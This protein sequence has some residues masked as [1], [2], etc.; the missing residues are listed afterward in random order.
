MYNKI[1]ILI[2]KGAIVTIGKNFI[3]SSGDY[4]NPLS[5][6]MGGGIYAGRNAVIRIGNNVGVSSSCIWCINHISIGDNAK[7]GADVIIIDNDAH[8]LD[9][10]NRRNSELDIANSSPIHI[11]EDVLIGTRCI[12]LKGVSIGA[13][14][15]IGAGSVVTKDIPSDCIAAGN[16]CRVIKYL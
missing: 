10:I 13:R 5:R 4:Q 14:S 11:E 9:Y 12:I 3:F 15:I 2:H 7:I 1:G 16:P 8:S 6:N